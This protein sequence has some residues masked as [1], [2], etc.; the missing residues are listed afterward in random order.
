[1]PY[2][3]IATGARLAYVDTAP[4]DTARAIVIAVHGMLGTAQTDLGHVIEWLTPDYR[5]LGPTMR[6]Y[7]Y[8]QPKPR[9]FPPDFYRRDTRDLIAFMDA[10]GIEKAHILGYSDGGEIALLAGGLVP[11][12]CLSVTAWGAVGYFGPKLREVVTHPTYP[13]RLA[14]TPTE[15]TRHGIMDRL[16]FAHEWI[17]AV[18]H[19]V[20]AGGDVSLS[21]A[22]QITAPLLLMLGQRDT[23]NPAAYA[24]RYIQQVG[25]GRLEMFDCG[26]PVHDEQTAAFQRVVGA[27][28]KEASV[29]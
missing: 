22:D 6:G 15:M 2:I 16:A 27:F 25:H 1:M 20:D 28:L 13:E 7:G 3:D 26:H 12:R 29:S 11:D 4:D 10:L 17:D 21:T 19:I 23:L 24:E 9:T 14:P 5:V 18:L 8:S